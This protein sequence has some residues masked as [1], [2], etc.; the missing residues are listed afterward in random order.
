MVISPLLRVSKNM[1]ISPLKL[2]VFPLF[3]VSCA[4]VTGSRNQPVSITT[5]SQGGV[6]KDATCVLTNDKGQWHA[7]TPGSV[8]IHKSYGDMS[9]SCSKNELRGV[10][11]FKSQSEGAVWGN[12]V[13]GGLIGYAL[14]SSS[15]AGFSYPQIMNVELS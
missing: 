10:S 2:L 9:I 7:N 12:V 15:G 3:M 11:T 5:S 1:Q 13:A 14:D 6:V 8:M 4:S